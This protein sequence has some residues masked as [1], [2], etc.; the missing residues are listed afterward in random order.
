MSNGSTYG[1]WSSPAMEWKLTVSR[2]TDESGR[3]DTTD[4]SQCDDAELV[5]LARRRP[6]CSVRRTGAAAPASR[7]PAVSSLDA[8]SRG[9]KRFGQESFVRAW[10]GLS[11]FK[12][13]A[14]FRA[15]TP[16]AS[17]IPIDDRSLDLAA[18]DVV[19]VDLASAVVSRRGSG[20]WKSNW[21]VA[22]SS[23]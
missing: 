20:Y 8:P 13:D 11:R 17:A 10:R 19:D 5:R 6:R 15:T 14:Q 1:D 7:L 18:G 9:C 4:L 23:C 3:S 2:A 21:N 12:G 16:P 22:S